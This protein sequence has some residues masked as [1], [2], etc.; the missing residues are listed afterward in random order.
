M[1]MELLLY[2]NLNISL[3]CLTAPDNLQHKIHTLLLVFEDNQPIQPAPV[4]ASS[5]FNYKPIIQPTVVFH[6][7]SKLS[8]ELAMMVQKPFLNRTRVT[9]KHNRSIL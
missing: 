5:T 4:T 9:K 2:Y 7:S 1:N 6:S 8:T 3:L